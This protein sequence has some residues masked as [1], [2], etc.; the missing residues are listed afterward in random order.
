MELTFGSD[1]LEGCKNNA[2][3]TQ[4]NSGTVQRLEFGDICKVCMINTVAPQLYAYT[5]GL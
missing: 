1:E 4:L 2:W 3:L 5:K